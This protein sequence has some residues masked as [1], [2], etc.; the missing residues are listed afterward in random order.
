M[1]TQYLVANS[2]SQAVTQSRNYWRKILKREKIP[3]DT[4]DLLCMCMENPV[5]SKGI[6][7]IDQPEYDML[8]PLLTPQ[9]K[10]FADANLKPASDPYI[11][12]FLD[13]IESPI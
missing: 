2:L 11:M 13:E 6:V 1:P 7:I 8:Y 5:D 9:E 12:A 3:Q 4:T 10:A